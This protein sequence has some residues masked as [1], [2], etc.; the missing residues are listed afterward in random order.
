MYRSEGYEDQRQVPLN[1]I[2]LHKKVFPVQKS[3]EFE[4]FKIK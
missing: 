4:Q 3:S 1:A 2:W